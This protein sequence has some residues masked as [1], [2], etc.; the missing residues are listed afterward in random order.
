MAKKLELEELTNNNL[1]VS[2]DDPQNNDLISMMAIQELLNLKKLKTITRI[3]PE[4]VSNIS[5]LYIFSQTFNTG[6]TKNL[7]DMILQLQI[8]I[9]GLGRKELVQLV[10]K[11]EE[12]LTETK[13]LTSKDIFR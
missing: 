9:N 2:M 11:R 4:Q 13:R 12:M 5:K 10:Q 7:A 1:K 3:K 6:F 8:S